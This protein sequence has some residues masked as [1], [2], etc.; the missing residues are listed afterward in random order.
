MSR[1]SFPAPT[2]TVK[3][4]R[5]PP[6]GGGACGYDVLLFYSTLFY[7][8]ATVFI[9]MSSMRGNLP[10][11]THTLLARGN[12]RLSSF[13]FLSFSCGSARPAVSQSLWES[14]RCVSC[15]LTHSFLSAVLTC[16]HVSL[17]WAHFASPCVS[18]RFDPWSMEVCL[19]GS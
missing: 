7:C 8:R 6:L 13:S 17:L 5:G 15:P 14:G 1:Y 3:P 18:F 4:L 10:L 11:C 19:R 16:R 12:P 2:C 9:C